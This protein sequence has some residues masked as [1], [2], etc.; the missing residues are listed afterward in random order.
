MAHAINS[1]FLTSYILLT[2]YGKDNTKSLKNIYVILLIIEKK[3]KTSF[4]MKGG[5]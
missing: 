5:F 1:R 2:Q 4:G 3:L